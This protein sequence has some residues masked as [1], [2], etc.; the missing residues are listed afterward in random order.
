MERKI[1][2]KERLVMS[3]ILLLL[4]IGFAVMSGKFLT[5]QNSILSI[6]FL[7]LSLISGICLVGEVVLNSV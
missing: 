1:L 7:A 6:A 2:R 3:I 5:L 4:T